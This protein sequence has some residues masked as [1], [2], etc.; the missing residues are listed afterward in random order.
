MHQFY[1]LG[2]L[3]SLD[4][5]QVALIRKLR[6]EWQNGFLNGIG[7]KIE[8]KDDS[9]MMAM[10]R[11]FEEEAGFEYKEW[12]EFAIMKGKG[13]DVY[14]YRGKSDLSK[15]ESKTDEK[16]EIVDVANFESHSV[17]SNLSWLIPMALDVDK[18]RAEIF[19]P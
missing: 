12:D 4:L 5:Q 16:I 15:L 9:P 11:E 6:P 1:V 14:C 2:F 10:I 19:Y 7:G 17:L 13:W 8:F 3:F 18:V